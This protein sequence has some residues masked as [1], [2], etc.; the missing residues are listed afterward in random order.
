MSRY[1]HDDKKS[2]E[3]ELLSIKKA[4]DYYDELNL[5]CGILCIEGDI[6]ALSVGE[7]INDECALIHI[8]KAD[9]NYRTAYSV[10]NNL[11]LKN[12]FQDTVYVNREEDM[13]I[14]GI[15]KAKM[16]YKPCFMIE[17]YNLNFKIKW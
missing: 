5:K 10:I 9:Y 7:K 1:Y 2:Y 6:I 4:F 12:E 8:E 16:S 11:F 13:G 17:K 15:R 3:T 14:E